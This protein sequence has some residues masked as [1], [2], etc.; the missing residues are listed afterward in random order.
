MNDYDAGKQGQACRPE[1]ERQDKT[2]IKCKE[3]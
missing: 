3:A 2:A 1:I